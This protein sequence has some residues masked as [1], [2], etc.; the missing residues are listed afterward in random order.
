MT[1]QEIQQWHKDENEWW[2][3]FSS[4]MAKQWELDDYSNMILRKSMEQ[5]SFDFLMKN[6]GSLLDL[7][8]GSGWLSFQFE[9]NGM[10][11]L[12]LDFSDEQIK[13]A[14]NHKLE[15]DA[16]KSSFVCCDILSWDYSNHLQKFDSVHVSAF[17][18]HL[19]EQE[20]ITLF[21][22]ISRISK[23]EANIYLYEPLYF[24]HKK[25]NIVKKIFLFIVVKSFGLFIHHIPSFLNLWEKDYKDARK[26]GYTGASPHEAALNYEFLESVL[27]NTNLK[28]EDI[29]PVHYKSIVYA[30]L[31]FSMKKPF[32]NFFKKGIS[33][34]IKLD[35]FLFKFIGYKNMGYKKDFLL[36]SVKI[37]KTL[38]QKV[39]IHEL[40]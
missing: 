18:H 24:T 11:T 26:R 9:R 6:N 32:R 1:E 5:E 8:C 37:K 27:K 23:N 31:V 15:H 29:T 2:N 14:N 25:L 35:H 30:I 36:Y 22:V 4:I 39:D 40:S 16:K 38:S 7:G 28:I 12:G 20:L 13:L 10:T 17:L 3:K 19:P 34:I 33:G 21:E